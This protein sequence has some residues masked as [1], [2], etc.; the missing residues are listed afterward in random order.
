[1]PRSWLAVALLIGLMATAAPAVPAQAASGC[2]PSGGAGQPL[3][4]STEAPAGAALVVAGGGAGH[5][6]GLSQY[7]AR[8]AAL[9]GCS[10]DQ[11]LAVAYPGTTRTKLA[12]LDTVRVGLAQPSQQADAPLTV[13]VTAVDGDVGWRLC[14]ADGSC[15][16]VASQ[17]TGQRWQ[18]RAVRASATDADGGFVLE[19]VADDG[20]VTPV[21]HGGDYT[22]TLDAMHDATVVAVTVGARTW[23]LKHGYLRF[24]SYL[25]DAG[26]ARLFVVSHVTTGGGA[27]G[28]ARYLY[29]LAEMPSSWSTAALQAQAIAARTY[30]LDRA[31]TR[32]ADEANNPCRCDVVAT[33]ADQNYEGWSHER[34]DRQ[35]VDGRWAAAVDATA[36]QALT[37]DGQPILARYSASHGGASSAAADLRPDEPARP[38]LAAADWSRWETADGVDDPDRRWT[39]SFSR[40]DLATRFGMASVDSLVL[41]RLAEGHRPTARDTDGDG[42]PDGARVIGRDAQ[43]RPVEH[44]YSGPQLRSVLGLRSSRIAVAWQAGPDITTA[45]ACPPGKVPDA[46]FEDT[47]GSVHA[48]TIDCVVWWGLAHG[49]S[50]KR[51]APAASVTRAQMASFLANLVEAGAGSL[52]SDPPDAFG[53]DDGNVHEHAINQLA[54]AG[55]VNGTGHTGPDGRPTYAPDAPVTRGQMAS[56]L[57]RALGQLEGTALPA[58]LDYFT[59]DTGDTHQADINAVR[60][61]RVATG[62]TVDDTFAPGSPVT[63]AQLATFLARSLQRLVAEN[64]ASPPS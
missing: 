27:S 18:V 3:V 44:W 24:D 59:D 21:W 42:A 23:Q 8:G 61:A 36:G 52:P 28:L 38:Y 2:L 34:A 39:A 54:D 63:R 46:G 47:A 32:R 50:A 5:G 10:A 30:V 60:Q 55:L 48:A 29:G 7:G 17:P 19:R 57:A 33:V 20:T 45:D 62:V 25:P 35:T 26:H 22:T 56:F 31:R 53:D 4:T 64:R 14:D 6:M 41:I 1:M 9:L 13:P 37:M 16:Q 43:G 11:I 58:D 49:V 51:Y 12:A 40:A 15:Q